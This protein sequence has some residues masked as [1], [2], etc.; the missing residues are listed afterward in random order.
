M[1]CCVRDG[2][3]RGDGFVTCSVNVGVEVLMNV[4]WKTDG[5]TLAFLVFAPT[6]KDEADD[7]AVLAATAIV[8]I[9]MLVVVVI[10]NWASC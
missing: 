4:G 8:M 10:S 9:P 1:R 2:G 5:P 7:P 3:N 6:A